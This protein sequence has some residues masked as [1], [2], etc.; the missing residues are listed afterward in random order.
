MHKEAILLKK[1]LER[2]ERGWIEMTVSISTF[3]DL[4]REGLYAVPAKVIR[5]KDGGEKIK[6]VMPHANGANAIRS[7]SEWDVARGRIMEFI[8]EKGYNFAAIKSGAISNVYVLDIDTKDSL[9]KDIMADMPLWQRL[10]A[11]HGDPPT[12]QASTQS[13]GIHLYFSYVES[14]NNGLKSGKDFVGVDVG[15]Q[16]YGIDGRGEGGIAFCP[17]STLED[18]VAYTWNMAPMEHGA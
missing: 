13:G 4:A 16:L 9:E 1:A 3:D 14:I 10:I 17:P 12:L 7:G 15:G 8:Q 18:G 5:E 2:A 6:G 11:E